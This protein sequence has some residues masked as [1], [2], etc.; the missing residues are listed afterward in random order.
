MNSDLE[1]AS[2]GNCRVCSDRFPVSKL[3]DEHCPP[4]CCMEFL[5][6]EQVSVMKTKTRSERPRF[7]QNGILFPKSS[8]KRCNNEILGGFYDPAMMDLCRQ[9]KNVVNSRIVL[10]Q[11]E[12]SFEVKPVAIMKGVLGHL[13]AASRTSSDTWLDSLARECVRNVDKPIPDQLH[14]FYWLFPYDDY[15]SVHRDFA[16]PSIRGKIG[17][18]PSVFAVM[19]YFPVAF[20]VTQIDE[21]ANLR[22]L[23]FWRKS[24]LSTKAKIQIDLTSNLPRE[25]PEIIDSTNYVMTGEPA[26]YSI[27]A[28]PRKRRR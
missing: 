13:M 5:E 25:W 4:R 27:A 16:M 21:Y 12:I 23:D 8:C 22:N 20:L 1:I 28:T 26:E 18:A 19:K 10:P 2:E 24:S 14:I 17:S 7:R 3:T 9:V 11:P 15:A 6:S